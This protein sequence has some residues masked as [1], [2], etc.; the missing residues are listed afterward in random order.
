MV[1]RD[2]RKAGMRR[3]KVF[4]F[5]YLKGIETKRETDSERESQVEWGME[6]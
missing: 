2:W 6:R 3:H 5:I 4:L 1:A